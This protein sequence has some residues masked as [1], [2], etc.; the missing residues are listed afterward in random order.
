MSYNKK[1]IQTKNYIEIYEYGNPIPSGYKEPKKLKKEKTK[2]RDYDEL[3]D[4]EQLERLKRMANTR[5]KAK[6]DLVRLIDSNF[7]DKT[8]FLTLTTKEN[9]D[10][11]EKFN[12]MFDQFITR[13]NYHFLHTKKRKLKYVAVL[14][15]QERGAFHVHMLLFDI[16]FLNH[17]EL[18]DVWGHGFVWINKLDNL[19][20]SSNAGRYIAKYMEK[21]IGQELL[22]SKGKKSFYSSRNLKKPEVTKI[23]TDKSLESLIEYSNVVYESEYS[24]KIYK[25]GNYIDNP[26]KYKK[27]RIKDIK[28]N[29]SEVES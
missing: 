14:E 22:D 3:S 1:I 27:I 20:D 24:S 16:G 19:D 5:Q 21:S 17:K 15:K 2:R 10:S 6:W 23:F 12:K 8:S 26:V 4:K 9:I 18:T 28:D 25:D 7:D 11:R 13:F 29:I